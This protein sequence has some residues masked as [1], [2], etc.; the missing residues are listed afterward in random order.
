MHLLS[1]WVRMYDESLVGGA[2]GLDDVLVA[3]A[4]VTCAPL[5]LHV[6]AVAPAAAPAVLHKP[7]VLAA[8]S[9]VPD[10]RNLVV[11]SP[12]AVV[13]TD[14]LAAPGVIVHS[15]SVAAPVGSKDS[16]GD[17]G[18]VDKLLHL[19]LV[20]VPLVVEAGHVGAHVVARV[21]VSAGV[22]LVVEAG[23]VGA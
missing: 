8:L 6:A 17:G 18:D 19:V 20:G 11:Q 22:P 2:V 21:I 4:A 9:A 5:D 3:D 13:V 12:D 15:S 16:G 14:C 10:N 1:Y 23:H 7:V